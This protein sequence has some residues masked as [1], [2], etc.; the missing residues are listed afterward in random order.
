[1]SPVAARLL[2]SLLFLPAAAVA[3]TAKVDTGP[4]TVATSAP[5]PW[6]APNEAPVAS[7]L[8]SLMG[9]TVR[10]LPDRIDA[11]PPLGCRKPHYEFKAYPPD[12]LFQGGL[13]EP[14]KQAASL[15]FKSATIKTLE[16]GCEGAID[17]HFIDQNSALFALNNRIYRLDKKK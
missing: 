7:D 17:F 4:W 6:A 3:G 10:F 14:A 13:T 16:T 15:G 5:A 2:A 9:Q 8:Q 12:M 1:M 11:P